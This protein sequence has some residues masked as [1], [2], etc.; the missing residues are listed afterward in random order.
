[1]IQ[2]VLIT[3]KKLVMMH[4]ELLVLEMMATLPMV[5]PSFF[6]LGEKAANVE[7]ESA[8]DQQVQHLS[9]FLFISV[10]SFFLSLLFFTLLLHQV[11]GSTVGDTAGGSIGE[12]VV[13]ALKDSIADQLIQHL[14]HFFHLSHFFVIFIYHF[15]NVSPSIFWKQCW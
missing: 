13:D 9:H 1:M 10:T 8:P 15:Y 2:L 3:V 4:K 12:V 6:I 5:E 11:L 14:N 7:T